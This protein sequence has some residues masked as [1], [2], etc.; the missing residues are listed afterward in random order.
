MSIF[1]V[2]W[3]LKMSIN[4]KVL[5]IKYRPQFFDELVGQKII[6]QA[7][8]KSIEI[9]KIPNAFLFTGIRGVGKTT[10]ARILAKSLNCLNPNKK[11]CIN[12]QCN[13]CKQISESRHIDVLEM[14]A[15]SK[16]GVDDVRDLIEFSR[17][18]P[19]S[20]KYKIFIIDEVHMLSKQ[21][22]NALLKTLEEPPEYLKFIFATTEANKIPITVL[23]RCQRFDLMRISFDELLNFLK[24]VMSL[25]EK[26][27][28]E[29][30]L[31]LI[32]KISEGSVRDAL[33]LLDRL[34]LSNNDHNEK[35]DLKSAQEIFGYFDKSYILDIVSELLKGNENKVLELYKNIYNQG[36]EPK[37][38]I[39]NF[40]EIIYYLKNHNSINSLNLSIEFTETD[41]K[42]I[43][44]IASK[45][46]N[47][48]I[49]LFWEFSVNI[50]NE[51]NLV[52]NQHLAVEMFLVRLMY[53]K[54][55]VPGETESL[56][57]L[58]NIGVSEKDDL[59][60]KDYAKKK[61]K[62]LNNNKTIN[63]IKFSS[64]EQKKI[65]PENK[66]ISNKSKINSFSE[67]I[68]MCAFK[69][70]IML[71]YEL[72]NNVNLISFKNNNIEIS[73][74][75]NLNKDFIKN[76]TSKLLEWTGERWIIM[77]SKKL[78]SKTMKETKT[79]GKKN[80]LED[81]RNSNTYKKAIDLFPD[82]EIINI[83]NLEED[84]NE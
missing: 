57:D 84:S 7:I 25:E 69:K 11:N 23:S 46:D 30:I 33:S 9:N 51:I 65:S 17:Y 72:E 68:S 43:K 62:D 83:K 12:N 60:N 39:N 77:L 78:G 6:V 61:E 79:Q 14:D 58:N 13:N 15:A 76:L 18:G 45:I 5:A 32:V 55:K 2:G 37:L 54:K 59:T 52:A 35:L 27:L 47:R 56:E 20:S 1:Q 19:T 66:K 28:D 73:F 34:L 53:L 82:L 49:L 4:K 81:I 63:Q 16:T 64:Q 24:R 70:E 36:V 26:V 71:K 29:D 48:I 3:S 74:N 44:D 42:K 38:F 10:I 8:K 50:L 80:E 40:L 21:A 31:K 67:L 41:F 22:F 75:E